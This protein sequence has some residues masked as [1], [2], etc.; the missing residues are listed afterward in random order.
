MEGSD[1]SEDLLQPSMNVVLIFIQIQ[2]QF[3]AK[4]KT[5]E[6]NNTRWKGQ[7]VADIIMLND[8]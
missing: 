1:E 8:R 3:V 6:T 7:P 2:Q 4:I 5:N